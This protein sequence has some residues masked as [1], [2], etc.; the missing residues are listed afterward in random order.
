M[1]A[2]FLWLRL[3]PNRA[4]NTKATK[5]TVKRRNR[6]LNDKFRVNCLRLS[7]IRRCLLPANRLEPRL[8]IS[9]T[10]ALN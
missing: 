10:R 2:Q 7:L 1:S 6:N 5:V 9:A 8:R 4:L 3:C